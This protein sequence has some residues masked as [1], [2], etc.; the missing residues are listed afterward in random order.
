MSFERQLKEMLNENTDQNLSAIIQEVIENCE[1]WGIKDLIKI[2]AIIAR[3]LNIGF[4]FISKGV[5]TGYNGFVLNIKEA[6]EKASSTPL[7]NEKTD[8]VLEKLAE[9]YNFKD[10]KVEDAFKMVKDKKYYDEVKINR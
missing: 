10:A 4:N 2:A 9:K 6:L 1:D 7:A 3:V 8:I 5:N